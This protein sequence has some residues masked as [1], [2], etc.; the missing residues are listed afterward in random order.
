MFL[1]LFS[2]NDIFD[3]KYFETVKMIHPENIKI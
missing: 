2:F 3:F 1:N